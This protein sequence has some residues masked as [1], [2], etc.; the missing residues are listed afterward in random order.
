MKISGRTQPLFPR[1]TILEALQVI[2]RLGFEGVEISL[3]TDEF[4]PDRVT[5]QRAA[6]VREQVAQLGLDPH[7]LGYHKDYIYDDEQLGLMQDAIRLAP[8][9]GADMLIFSGG[10]K[11][12]GADGEAEWQRMIERTRPLV[13]LAEEV[14]ITLAQEFEPGFIVGS[15]SDLLRLF[16]EIPSPALAANLDLGHVFLCDPDPL[17]AIAQLKGKIVHGHIENMRAGVHNH[18]LPQEGDMNLAAYLSALREAGFTG[19][20]A[21]DLY[22]YDYEAVAPEAIAA[23]RRAMG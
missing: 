21:L 23:I 11:R 10:S 17:S 12:A 14:G 3:E 8:A 18:L 19:A 9:F 15:T 16:D 22:A 2:C 13:R 1:Y 6:Q 20:L 7:V 4:T 5:L